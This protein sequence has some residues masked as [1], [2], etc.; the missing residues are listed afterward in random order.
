MSW[1]NELLGEAKHLR[2]K[3]KGGEMQVAHL[4]VRRAKR[5][6]CGELQ[7]G[8]A[9]V[10]I[11]SRPSDIVSSPVKVPPADNFARLALDS[12]HINIE[13]GLP[14]RLGREF[15]PFAPAHRAEDLFFL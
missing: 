10:L 12:R 3:S 5:G 2:Q 6:G 7:W 13:S 11:A 8:V 1:L 14:N 9:F 4:R 15:P